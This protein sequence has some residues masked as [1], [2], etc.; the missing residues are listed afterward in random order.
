MVQNKIDIL[1]LTET[2]STSKETD[3]IWI[4]S[5]DLNMDRYNLTSAIR[6][7][8]R[9]GGLALIT[10]NDFKVKLDSN[11]EFRTFQFTKWYV[12]LMHTNI[13]VLGIY[14]PPAGSPVEFLTEFTNWIIDVMAHKTNLLVAGDFNLHINNEN[15]ENA[16]NFI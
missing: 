8:R 10:K 2:W 14:R 15:D 1:L 16:A 13:T 12:Q 6:E 11:A 5:P 9:V 4:D 3:K 7:N